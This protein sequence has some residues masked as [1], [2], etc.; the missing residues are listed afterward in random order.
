MKLITKEIEA[1]LIKS[2]LY[3]HEGNPRPDVIVKFF[4]PWTN[5]TWYVI[6][7]EKQEEGDWLFFGLVEGH[8]TELGYF[9]L[10][11]LQSVKGPGGL[12]IERDMYFTNMVLDTSVTPA[13]VVPK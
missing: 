1:K 8:E 5:W 4:T 10:S 11:E 12:T 3:S 7:G 9:T 13:K 6:E 2:P